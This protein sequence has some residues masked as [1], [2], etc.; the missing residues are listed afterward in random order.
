MTMLMSAGGA[1][2][3]PVTQAENAAIIGWMRKNL[4]DPHSLRSVRISDSATVSGANGQLVTVVCVDFN[5]KD[6]VGGYTE[7]Y[8]M[9]FVPTSGGLTYSNTSSN[10]VAATC[11]LP[12]ILMRAVPELGSAR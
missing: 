11:Y 4:A 12:Q 5:T 1:E 8:R 3:R 7:L 10:V 6:K 9:A 2:A